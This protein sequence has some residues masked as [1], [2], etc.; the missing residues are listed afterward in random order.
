M[1]KPDGAAMTYRYTVQ[2]TI[3]TVVSS[4]PGPAFIPFTRSLAC[5]SP[6]F[7]VIPEHD[8]ANPSPHTKGSDES[9]SAPNGQV[10]VC[11]Y[12]RG[13][14]RSK[15][16]NPS[17]I[18]PMPRASAPSST[19]STYH[20]VLLPGQAEAELKAP[21]AQ[22]GPPKP[23]PAPKPAPRPQQPRPIP[24]VSAQPGLLPVPSLAQPVGAEI[25]F[26]QSGPTAE[27]LHPHQLSR[28]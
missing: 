14:H 9:E 10:T 21:P 11:R 28:H 18:Q 23:D 24:S 26:K 19:I 22:S 12:I 6:T 1:Y 3:T 13:N 16:L 8:S 17:S 5:C 2:F 25:A 20:L 27:G 4:W 15:V 7:R